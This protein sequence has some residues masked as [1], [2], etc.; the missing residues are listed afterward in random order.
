MR[1]RRVLAA[2]LTLAALTSVVGCSAATSTVKTMVQQGVETTSTGP[3]N[4]VPA[5]NAQNAVDKLNNSVQQT[6][7]NAQDAGN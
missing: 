5:N 7:Q 3:H 1:M 6:E 4:V 2:A